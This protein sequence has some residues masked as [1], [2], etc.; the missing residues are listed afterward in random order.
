VLSDNNPMI[1]VERPISATIFGAAIVIGGILLITG[2]R[3]KAAQA[4]VL[5]TSETALVEAKG[6]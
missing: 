3:R 4:S 1:F 5:A 6:K 2:R